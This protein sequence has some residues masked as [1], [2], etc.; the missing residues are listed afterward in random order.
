MRTIT[1]LPSR[2]L[3]RRD[4]AA[5]DDNRFQVS[6]YGGIVKE[7]EIRIYAIKIATSDTAHA[8]GFD[9]SQEQWQHLTSMDAADLAAADSQLDAVLDDWVK[10]R[11]GTR[12]EVLKTV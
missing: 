12:L 8:L 6:P 10:E 2:P 11:Y 3:R 4:V 9:D 7:D 1:R 5:L